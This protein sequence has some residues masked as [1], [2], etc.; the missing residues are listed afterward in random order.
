MGFLDGSHH[1]VLKIAVCLRVVDTSLGCVFGCHLL[2]DY[3]VP[4]KLHFFCELAHGNPDF[5]IV[6]EEKIVC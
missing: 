4:A 1:A 6:E 3:Y 5:F 2:Y